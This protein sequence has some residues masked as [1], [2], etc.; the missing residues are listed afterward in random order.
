[1]SYCKMGGIIMK[2]ILSIIAILSIC[3][4]LTACNSSTENV[5]ETKRLDELELVN[6]QADYIH[7]AESFDDIEKVS[8]LVVVGKFIDDEKVCYERYE[9]D[10]Y[11][12]KDVLCEIISSCPMQITKVLSGNAK[13]GDVVNVLQ[14]EGRWEDRYITHS[15]LTPMQKGDEWVFCLGRSNSDKYDGY[16]CV[17]ESWGRY[18]TK[19]VS[20][21]EKIS[22]SDYGER[23]VYELGDFNE[24][25]YN[26]LVEKYDV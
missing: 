16:W 11:F 22:F 12:K 19:N 8:E 5:S 10:D 20:A 3:G 17:S 24:N 15:A 6:I 18:P 4:T 9:Y 14:R 21:N 25:F 1:M 2:K 7:L 13:V 26:Q 23:G